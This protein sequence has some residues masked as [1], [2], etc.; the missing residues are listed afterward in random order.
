MVQIHV[1]VCVQC[2]CV[3]TALTFFYSGQP[4]TGR[5]CPTHLRS[6]A[7]E[8]GIT[9]QIS[10]HCNCAADPHGVNFCGHTEAGI[11]AVSVALAFNLPGNGDICSRSNTGEAGWSS[12][13]N[14][15]IFYL[16]HNPH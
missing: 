12:S 14:T 7:L 16:F 5:C 8:C 10:S 4:S 6:V 15:D 3:Y 9:G 13:V 1:Y 2:V 11:T